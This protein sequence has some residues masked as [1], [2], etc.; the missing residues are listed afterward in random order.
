L[1]VVAPPQCKPDHGSGQNADGKGTARSEALLKAWQPE[2]KAGG[3][4]G[5]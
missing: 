2:L 5:H 1:F 3:A 4:W